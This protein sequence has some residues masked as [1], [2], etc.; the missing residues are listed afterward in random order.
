MGAIFISYRRADSEGQ[1]GRL[2]RDLSERFG[3][4]SVLFDVVGM[5]KGL[6]FRQTIER[7]L[8]ASAVLLAVMGRGWAQAVDDGGRRRLDDPKDLVRL[9]IANALRKGIPVIPVLV[10]G[11]RMPD[12]SE[13][14]ADLKDLVFRDGVE[15]THARWDADVQLLIDALVPLVPESKGAADWLKRNARGLAAGAVLV[16]GVAGGVVLYAGFVSPKPETSAAP[17]PVFV[18]APGPVLLPAPAPA[19]AASQPASAP[20]PTAAAPPTSAPA[21]SQPGSQPGPASGPPAFPPP[22]PAPV[23]SAVMKKGEAAKLDDIVRWMASIN[24]LRLEALVVTGHTDGTLPEAAAQKLSLQRATV[25]KKYLVA[26]GVPADRI[27]TEGK[28]GRQPVAD[29]GSAAGRAAN[30]RAGVEVVGKVS[31]GGKVEA[32]KFS[33]EVRFE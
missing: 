33:S 12:E 27:F 22:P 4:A 25:V 30:N 8:G 7:R 3:K 19:Q 17:G 18:P 15:L 13:L 32:R 10:G 28:G 11:A 26:K 5:P 2:F 16:G 1:A 14:P 24:D 23:P 20:A 21:A 6:D 9:E 31:A 29:N